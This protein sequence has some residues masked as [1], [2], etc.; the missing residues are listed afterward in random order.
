MNRSDVLILDIQWLRGNANQCFVKELVFTSANDLN[1]SFYHFLPPFSEKELLPIVRQSNIY[2][3]NNINLLKWE[4]GEVP[5]TA[6]P[7]I[8]QKLSKFKKILVHGLEKQKFLKQYLNNIEAVPEM[9]SFFAVPAY[10]HQCPHH[11][12]DFHRCALH[13]IMQIMFHCE[14]INLYNKFCIKK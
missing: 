13:H 6:L 14:R 9:K 4:D 8:L 12:P 7:C 11:P 3:S 5:Y 10:M 2:C 1:F